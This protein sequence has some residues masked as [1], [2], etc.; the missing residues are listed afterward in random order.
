MSMDKHSDFAPQQLQLFGCDVSVEPMLASI[1]VVESFVIAR[2]GLYLV[3]SATS[4]GTSNA[5]PV[6]EHSTTIDERLIGRTKL[7]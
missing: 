5:Q 7:F 6:A 4:A 3:S 1:T 2:P